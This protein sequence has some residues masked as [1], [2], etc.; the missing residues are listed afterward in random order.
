MNSR[1]RAFHRRARQTRRILVLES[2]EERQLLSTDLEGD[3]LASALSVSLT[4]GVMYQHQASIGDGDH[5]TGDV[6]LYKVD[7]TA[8]QYL[9]VVVNA[10]NLDEGGSLSNLDSYL[11]V[12]D[13]SG[14][15]LAYNDD[16][17]NPYN[18]VSSTD[19]SL[20]FSAASSGTYYLGVT[21][22]GNSAYNPNTVGSGINSTSGAYRLELKLANSAPPTAPTGFAASASSTTQINLTWSNVSGATGY[23]IER[24]PNGSTGWTVIATPGAGSTTYSDTGVT[25]N[26]RY[27]YRIQA[28]NEGGGSP[29]SSTILSTTPPEA[30]DGLTATPISATEIDLSWT[31]HTASGWNNYVE[32]SLDGTTGWQIIAI[33]SGS[34]STYAATGPFN[35]STPYYFRVRTYSTLGLYST[36]AT[37]NVTTQAFPSQPVLNP[38]TELSD[39]SIS[40]TWTDVPGETGFQVLR[41]V[42]NSGLWT[43]VATPAAGVTSYTDTDVHEATL[44]AYRLIATSSV[45]NSAPS[46]TLSVASPP[47]APTDL[48]AT[49][50]S[51]GQINLAWTNHS[52]AANYYYVEESLDGT[53]GWQ[54]VA[55][56]VNSGATSFTVTGS[57]SGS[58]NYYFRV[59]AYAFTG[60]NSSYATVTATTPAFP[61]A[62][63]LSLPT[64]ASDTSVT[65]TW[66]DV[67]GETGF[68]VERSLNNSTWAT[69]GTVAAGV[70]TFT[71]TGL[72]ESTTY[73]YRLIATNAAGDSAASASRGV[74]TQPSAP[75][76]LAADAVSFNQIDLTWTDHSASA[77]YYYVEQSTDGSTWQS[78]ASIYGSTTTSYTATGPFQG[79]T[80]YYFRVRA[81][82]TSGVYST[83]ATANVTTPAFPNAPSLS[84]VTAQS[85][86]AIQVSWTDVAGETG[87]RIERL[88]GSTWTSEGTVGA[89]V[90]TFTDT[91][92]HESTSYSYRVV[93][94]NAIG[95]SAP[96]GTLSAT[97]TPAAPTDVAANVVSGSRIDLSWTNHSTVASAYYIE[98]SA[99]G[100]NWQLMGSVPSSAT[101]YSVTGTFNGLTSYYF[102]VRAYGFSSGYSSYATLTVT[103]P[104]LP[105]APSLSSATAQSDSSIKLSWNDVTGET[106]YR[107]ERLVGST[108]TSEGTVGA[109]VTTFTDTGLHESTSYSYRVVATN[110]IGDSAPSG[111]LSATTTPAAPT[112]LTANVVSGS[113][114]DLSWTNHST[115]ASTYYIE[116]SADGSNWQQVGSVPSST[117][118]YSVTDTFNRQTSYYFRIRAYGFFGG[119]SSYA[120]VSVTTPLFPYSPAINWVGLQTDTSVTLSW[121]NAPGESGFRVERS[122]NNGTWVTAGTVASGV[123]TFTDTGLQESSSY[124]YRVVATSALG[125][126]APSPTMSIATQPAS[127]TG[128]SVA[129]V[130]GGQI[131]LTWTNHSALA[132]TYY[133]EES[134]NGTTWQQVGSV[135]GTLSNYS[136]SG[137]FTGATTY[138]FRV[139]AYAFTGGYSSYASASPVTTPAFA[140]QPVLNSATAQSSSSVA[141][142]WTDVSGE[143]GYRVE[144]SPNNST[145]TAVGTVGSG[146]TT[147]TD[148]G[149]SEST[150]YYYRVI[151]TNAAG[152]SAPSASRNVVTQTAAPT[153]LS[154]TVVSGGQINLT[155]TNQSS[156]ASS[157]YIEESTNGTT[158]QQ[159]ATVNGTLSSYSANGPFTGLTTY[160]FRVRASAFTGGY[161]S[162][163]SASPV[164]TPAFANQ[165]VLNPASAQ[166]SSSVALVWSDVSG[167]TGFRVERS[168]NNS[169]WTSVGTIASGVTTFTDTG[170]NEST[171][172]YYRVIATNGAGDSAPSATQ[173][174]VTQP[175]AP[176]GLTATV[177]SSTQA[178]LSWTNH[179]STASTYYIEESIDGTAWQQVGSTN[180]TT[181]SYS[182]AGSFN[183]STTYY[184][185]VRAYAFPSAYSTY[186]TATATTASFPSQP[187]LSSVTATSDTSVT[188]SWTDATGETGYR[189][190]RSP[191]NSTW[192]AV[193][194]VDSG[195]TTFTNAGLNE[196]TTYYYRVIAT[197]TTGDS[198]PSATR[199]VA[200]PTAAPTGLSATVVSGGQISLTWTNHSL[201]ASTYFVEQSANG[202][203]W[204]Q[205]G[206]VNATLS[207]YLATGPFNGSATYYFRVRASTLFS[208]NY[209]NYATVTVTTPAFAG[210]PV[211][212]SA[213]AQS[214]DSVALV[215]TDVPGETGYRV[216]R[217]PNNSTWTAVGTVGSGVTTFT[218]TGLSESTTYYYRVIATNGA[219][220]SAP[221]A[222][223]NVV[224]QP[225]A[226]TGLLATVISGGQIDLTWTNQS[227]KAS[228]YFI[229]ESTDG[230]TWQQ[231]GMVNGTLSS[232]S[233]T[234]PFIG[235][236]TYYFRVR[237]SSSPGGYSTYTPVASVVTPAFP[238]QPTLSTV[239]A[240]SDT[241]VALSWADLAGETGYRVERSPGNNGT[242]TL[243]GTVSAGVTTF[244]DTGLT[245]GTSYT[246]RVI[247][248]SAA[249]DSAPSATRA[250]TTFPTAPSDLTTNAISAS[251]VD[252]TWV[253]HSS[254]ATSYMI[255]QSTDGTTWQQLGSV[256]S[257][258]NSFSAT[259]PFDGSTPYYFR[260]RA[261]EIPNVY[262]VYSATSTV[263][264][265][266]YPSRPTLLSVSAQSDSANILTWSDVAG[267]TGFRV[268]RAVTPGGPWNVLAVLG[269]GITSY[270]DTGL[271]EGSSF[272]YRVVATNAIGDSFPSAS[273]TSSIFIDAPTD[274]TAT[275]VSGGQINLSWTNH[276]TIATNYSVDQSLDGVNWQQLTVLTGV[277]TVTVTGIFASSSTYYYRVHAT[278]SNRSSDYATTSVAIPAYPARPTISTV[279]AVS[280]SSANLAWS[281]VAGE[282]G[283]RI[284]R[285]NDGGVTWVLAGTVAAGVTSFTDTG[286]AEATRY[287]YR[288]TA[289]NVVGDSSSSAIV[290]VLTFPASPDSVT[291]TAVSGS[292][293]NLAWLDRSNGE[294]GYKIEQSTSANGPWTSVGNTAANITAYTITGVFA[295]S[296]TYYFRVTA[297]NGTGNSDPSLT[298][299]TTAGWPNV[300]TDLT[301][302]TAS[303][304][305]INLTW[306]PSSGATSYVIERSLGASNSWAQ[307]GI[308]A[309]DITHYYDS[310]LS[311]GTTY[312][313]RVR[314]T[315]SLGASANSASATA[316]TTYSTPT[317]TIPASID[318]ATVTGKTATLTGLGGVQGGEQRLSYTWSVVSMPTGAP[319]PTFSAN[320]TNAAKT[321]VVTFGMAGSYT[322]QLTISNGTASTTS[323]IVA[324]AVSQT[325]TNIAI[326]PAA[327]IVLP[328]ATQQFTADETDQF[329]Q[330]MANAAAIDWSLP[331]G[332]PGEIDAN[333]LYTAPDE[334]SGADDVP[335]SVN[336]SGGGLSTT[337]QG[338]V[339]DKVK[340]DF[341]DL[342]VGTRITDQYA[343][344]KFST[345]DGQ[346]NQVISDWAAHAIG[347]LPLS[348]NN[349]DRNLYVDFKL[350]ADDLKFDFGWV[351]Q[352]GE[353][354]QVHVFQD[355]PDGPIETTVPMIGPG[356]MTI[357]T[358]D[359]GQYKGITRI[360][361]VGIID[362]AGLVYDNFTF[363]PEGPDLDVD[364]NNENDYDPDFPREY[365]DGPEDQIENQDGTTGKI[366]A[367][368][369]ADTNGDSVP[370]F[371]E[372]FG[373]NGEVEVSTP[374]VHFVPVVL[375]LPQNADFDKIKLI[376]DYSGSDPTGVTVTAGTDG[377]VYTPGDGRL[378]L[379]TK[380][381][382]EDRNEDGVGDGG[383][384]ITP[385]VPFS[386][387][388]IGMDAD[389]R[390]V[391]L[392]LEAV[393]P[394]NEIDTDG[395][396]DKIKIGLDPDG[397]G[398]E[399]VVA[400]DTIRVSVSK[401]V[402]I[403]LNLGDSQPSVDQDKPR[404]LTPD[405]IAS[406]NQ[407][408]SEWLLALGAP[409]VPA[410]A[411]GYS[412]LQQ[413]TQIA[414]SKLQTARSNASALASV[415]NDPTSSKAAYLSAYRNAAYAY[416][417]YINAYQEAMLVKV[418]FLDNEWYLSSSDTALLEQVDALP[419]RVDG[420]DVNLTPD[421]WSGLYDVHDQ[422]GEN[423]S[424]LI[425]ST[426]YVEGAMEGGL[427]GLVVG[428]AFIGAMVIGGPLVP[429]AMGAGSIL[430]GAGIG[431]AAATR[432][433]DGQS[434]AEIILG[435]AADVSG[436]NALYI[437]ITGTDAVTGQ[438]VPLTPNEQGKQFG[439]GLSAL[440]L[441]ITGAAASNGPPQTVTFNVPGPGFWPRAGNFGGF[442]LL[443]G[444]GGTG[445]LAIAPPAFQPIALPVP[446]A[447]VQVATASL[448]A[449]QLVAYMTAPSGI[450]RDGY[451]WDDYGDDGDGIDLTEIQQRRTSY[452][453]GE[454]QGREYLLN[455][456]LSDTNFVNPLEFNGEF[457]NGFDSVMKDANGEYW[458]VEYKGG[459]ADLQVTKSGKKQMS[460]AWVQDVLVRMNRQSRK[461]AGVDDPWAIILKA[462]LDAGRLHGIAVKTPFLTEMRQQYGNPYTMQ[463]WNY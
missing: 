346:Y 237:D 214:S 410:S 171:T 61:N 319:S 236:S 177:V 148:T 93:A 286:L 416:D 103:T 226:P 250:I 195:V 193:G 376:V 231:V 20:N 407:A 375:E 151:A 180:S 335:I 294:T 235:E 412:D 99:D 113:R 383:D 317:V 266:D 173:S 351:N 332:T 76:G 445:S 409:S 223:R 8:G 162:Y 283:F 374:D 441:T 388:D 447:H 415:A 168:P 297:Y 198:A 22:Y 78:I 154:A 212:S 389:N 202:T 268:E 295:G 240:Q 275:V 437:G 434:T 390:I 431:T 408:R 111:T 59:H 430:L 15:Q 329:G 369:S 159:L 49:V 84:S 207:S 140:G 401:T 182:V 460:R 315:N 42:N 458:I 46:A 147:Y 28:S 391:T 129:V 4:P 91:G 257:N 218:D 18:G 290:S 245:E 219:G 190:E 371:A 38:V 33:L 271:R 328:G 457:G 225:V 152:D 274:L 137:P 397:D 31:N 132:S 262:S 449:T 428:G 352:T 145:W 355:G 25:E 170:L 233:A 313:Y 246:Y 81:Y 102:R 285:S 343:L 361:I 358:M 35:G 253:N 454:Q 403:F 188:L 429:I 258:V 86:S 204:Q 146:V 379:W 98:E 206:T 216:E 234:G 310:G 307:I 308:V 232:Y 128:L 337:A 272:A 136:A 3:I 303:T 54:Q 39:T 339:T 175:A 322:F 92:L 452:E 372:G 107:I 265:P 244:T 311:D 104:A 347:T 183:G 114:I 7:L 186:S 135:S 208:G 316:I 85:D 451:K 393:A 426:D 462:E 221:S 13:A 24:S 73:Y 9:S 187:T 169:T 191:N 349:Y 51:G 94:T 360:E 418:Q 364:S 370:D 427:T 79:S 336:A 241:T 153:G 127:P 176:T 344:V 435:T 141:L 119:Y 220:D 323:N 62:P 312:S 52:T 248:T 149:L 270:T 210:Q 166:S 172:Y 423:L 398:P 439:T 32:Q 456:G 192:T 41:S 252:L 165:P 348:S 209:S 264:T 239:A 278:Y 341:D 72:S 326:S 71:D 105:N 23:S 118:A 359:L 324:T 58:T 131:N 2:L 463:T 279:T 368:N 380:D 417:V 122:L 11:R 267:E 95:D 414:Q 404:G 138:Y 155:W 301:A 194:T 228:T 432:A 288:L 203:T 215:W 70:T 179:S 108:W 89:G 75:T 82:S 419:I 342:A 384:Y 287:N 350:P 356:D 386:P 363:K 424:D 345:D 222:S 123:T 161:S 282:S 112:G 444:S 12:F 284:D 399:G 26:S 130:S 14:N 30:P 64:T 184:F 63:T 340:I 396:A 10:R 256:G 80:T 200:T 387:S 17:V 60:G 293:I 377:P 450:D 334:S 261:Y 90:T 438:T 50:V 120:T 300:P 196:S 77:F 5:P 109:G 83:Y 100:S 6:D 373:P 362:P 144:R 56:L 227:S 57:F 381:G 133:I 197:N 459:T 320:G 385:G 420:I 304:S 143:T 395:A 29:Y 280:N 126:S 405:D 433:N 309:G 402:A 117:T 367:V 296:T 406:F 354:G 230:T 448:G 269:A 19:S 157:Y 461:T 276:S 273:L 443:G 378:R 116:E 382:S 333:G 96:S 260:V 302:T 21:S 277:S 106:G 254:K 40:L 413:F 124:T 74:T 47:A 67:S 43:T 211:L 255:E 55:T 281:D 436:A 44:Y 306:S 27:Y 247:A 167:E 181:T 68:R 48:T 164:T 139:R 289:T 305:Q 36:Y 37:A 110:A 321:A 365:L 156:A 65:L 158:W 201:T 394:K 134:T 185:R 69:A 97:T 327:A 189:V 53:T 66:G 249:G 242:W 243:A 314:A 238:T 425:D 88:V 291:V 217:S 366:L 318:A 213:T 45:G 178:N 115:V 331:D 224:T 125:D 453:V 142:V 446:M 338:K 353:I 421:Q 400:T 251:R 101:A 411:Y 392:W 357:G 229:E 163:A 160:Y 259:G 16:A 292:Q 87:Y 299:V 34:A 150:T 442:Q 325:L 422:V 330:P 174:V 263:T 199:N 1:A 121:T 440:A 205:V 455:Q 298:S